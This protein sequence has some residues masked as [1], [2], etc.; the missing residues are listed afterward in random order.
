MKIIGHQAQS[1]FL[2]K[3]FELK[4]LAHAYLFSGQDKLGKKT[5]A[6]QWAC[7]I[8][9]QPFQRQNPGFILVEPRQK[10]IQISQIRDLIW[11][12]SLKPSFVSPKIAIIDKAHLMGIAAQHALLK[13]LE[14]PKGDSILILI[15]E[16]PELL[17]STI[18]SRCEIIKFYPVK[19]AEIRQYLEEQKLDQGKIQ[20]I[21]DFSQGKP[22]QAIDFALNPEKLD[23][24]RKTIKQ[25]KTIMGSSLGQRFQYVKELSQD[26]NLKEVLEAWLSFLRKHLI[27]QVQGI[28]DNDLQP[29]A[30]LKDSLSLLQ[31]INFLIS[32]TNVNPKLALETLFLNI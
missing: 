12:L 10:T 31:R 22:G 32:T 25:F 28:S 16:K 27:E 7:L 19:T 20:E 8:T 17:F 21:I 15:S 9:G 24:H 13:T 3:S 18:R 29:V 26:D 5:I 23:Q 30:E 4:R 1:R 11:R 14:E 6:L 2:K